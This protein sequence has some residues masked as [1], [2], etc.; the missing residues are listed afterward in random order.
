MI[1][2]QGELGPD[3]SPEAIAAGL[4]EV[5]QIQLL[6][7]LT[8]DELQELVD[9]CV[10]DGRIY[11]PPN[12]I[13][14]T[15]A[16]I[17]SLSARDR[18]SDLSSLGLRAKPRVPLASLHSVIW[19]C[20]NKADLLDELSWKLRWRLG[21]P[22]RTDLMSFISEKGPQGVIEEIVLTSMPVTQAIAERFKIK[23]ESV[24]TDP[25]L[26]DLLL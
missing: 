23:L 24:G 8:D 25:T 20:Y 18:P 6:L 15:R 2:Q 16:R 22:R 17:P 14:T 10:L 3:R 7:T 12:E 19:D 5:E 4:G 26:T 13:R 9:A 11:I 21:T 1:S